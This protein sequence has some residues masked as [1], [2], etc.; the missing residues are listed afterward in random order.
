MS[1]TKPV[2]P[3]NMS[4]QNIIPTYKHNIPK[5]TQILQIL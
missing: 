3:G 1:V 4:Y 2:L 5:I